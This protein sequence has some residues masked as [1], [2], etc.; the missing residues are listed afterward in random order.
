MNQV[1]P[2]DYSCIL[3]PQHNKGGLYIGNL[4]AA[5]NKHTLNSKPIKQHRTQYQSYPHLCQ[6]SLPYTFII[7]NTIHYAN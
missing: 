6:R 5:Q 7:T 4:E 3:P 1:Y 2:E